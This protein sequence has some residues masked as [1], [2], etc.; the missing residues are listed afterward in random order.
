MIPQEV[1]FDFGRRERIGIAEAVLCA[2][3][4]EAQIEHICGVGAPDAETVKRNAVASTRA[5]A[6]IGL[7]TES[8][9]NG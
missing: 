5:A 1:K 7:M 9:G 4:T 3:K 6:M 2:G 8:G